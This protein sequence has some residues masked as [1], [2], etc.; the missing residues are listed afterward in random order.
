MN[1]T[2]ESQHVLVTGGAGFLGTHLCRRLLEQGHDVTCL[3]NFQTGK[4]ENIHDLLGNPRFTLV[5]HDVVQPLP[6]QLFPT[7]IYNMACAASPA[8]YQADPVHTLQTCVYGAFNLLELAHANQAR[9]LQA[10][11]SEVYGDPKQHPQFE[12]YRGNVNIVGLRSCYDEGK[13]AAET[14]VADYARTRDLTV[15]IAR[16]FNTYGPYMAADDGRIVSTFIT[17]G[18]AGQPLT[19]YGDGSQTRSLCFVDDLIEGLLRLMNSNSAFQGPVNLGNPVEYTVLEIAHMLR[20]LTNST[21]GIEHHPLPPDD[22]RQ[23]CPDITLARHHL[24]WEPQTALA[25]GLEKTLGWFAANRAPLL[26]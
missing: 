18:L 1:R 21:A 6:Q 22:P 12:G 16:I 2:D 4:E 26:P 3:D 13:R 24:Q 14:L 15:K 9:F 5:R 11:T 19:V 20:E 17:Q 10:S 7:Q 25:Q 23:R 8:R